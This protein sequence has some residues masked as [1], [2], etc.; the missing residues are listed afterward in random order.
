MPGRLDPRRRYKSRATGKEAKDA[1][2][3]TREEMVEAEVAARHRRQPRR[4][5]AEKARK[6]RRV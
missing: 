3:R 4:G 5:A 6:A 2:T 1:A